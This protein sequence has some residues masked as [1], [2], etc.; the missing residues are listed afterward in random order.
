MSRTVLLVEDDSTLR[1]VLARLLVRE[2]HLV[3]AV[4]TAEEGLRLLDE[5]PVDLVV[6][7]IRLP[8]VGGLELLES[9]RRSSPQLPVI[10][11]S[12]AA[13]LE[14]AVRAIKLGAVDF[15]EKPIGSQR[16]LVTVGN[17][18]RFGD[19]RQ[20]ASDLE[21]VTDAAGDLVGDSAAMQR[22]RAMIAKVGPTDGR[23]LILGENGTG[24]EV[25]ANALHR[26]SKRAAGPLVK[27]N[28]AAVPAELVESELF[29]HEKGAFTGAARARRG[30]FE[31]ANGGTLFLDEVGDM[32]LAMQAK[33]L[34]VLQEGQLERV[35]GGRTIAVDVRVIGAT[36]RDPVKMVAEG[37]FRED[38]FY[39]LNVVTLKVPPLRERLED[40][41]VLA[42][43]F[44]GRIAERMGRRP[45]ELSDGALKALCRH[46]FPG[47]VREL[48]NV[49]ERLTILAD[50]DTI[51]ATDIE[52]Q[53]F[54]TA[55]TASLY[56][57]GVP[58]R[59][60]LHD[61]ERQ[62]LRAAID[63]LGGNKSAAA[64]ALGLDR[65]HF[66]KKCSQLGLDGD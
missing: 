5:V 45:V 17:V 6:T 3:E 25:V 4:G 48:M 54:A 59:E 43:S 33:L 12:G 18:L 56:R 44:A 40:V 19:L 37:A 30:R 39:R 52:T 7:D 60:L 11:M 53:L 38:L 66:Y 34:R 47:N 9:V 55:P 29:G 32:P 21:R 31:E 8:G 50:R 46:A 10:V 14:D 36:N 13:S 26:A 64:R 15:L 24:K 63:D 22:L 42:R 57:P 2:G 62:I 20:R 28:C 41:P 16:F 65:S 51:E 23:V 35:G 61:A 49:I 58:Y 27:L 1:E